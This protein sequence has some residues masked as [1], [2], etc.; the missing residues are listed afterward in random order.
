MTSRAIASSIR[1]LLSS[2]GVE[3]V[4]IAPAI[5]LPSVPDVFSAQAILGGV[6]SVICYGV[7]IP[8]GVI[9]AGNNALALYWRCCNMAYRSLDSISNQLCS[10]LEDKGHISVPIYSCY[11]WKIA[12]RK[13]WGLM[14]L[15]YWAQEAGLGKLT[16][17]G[18]LANPKYGTA[19]LLGGIITTLDLEASEETNW[20]GCPSACR[21]CVDACPVRAIDD[22]GEVDHNTCI[23]A[24]GANPLL[25]HLLRDSAIK[26]RFDFETIL[27]TVGVDDHG[28]Y[29]CFKCL[30]VCP[31]NASPRDNYT[32]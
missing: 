6:R 8:R 4:G 2:R 31:L 11:P 25:V 23:R 27:N 19:V 5:R 14:P 32:H 30:A 16:R 26:E 22:T 12:D 1:E 17:C 9:H 13:F 21:E 7:Q 24:S 18:L 15:I 20:Q 29:T 3:A 10:F 28:A